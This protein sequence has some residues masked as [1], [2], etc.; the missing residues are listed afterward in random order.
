MLKQKDKTWMEMTGYVRERQLQRQKTKQKQ[1]TIK[2]K[3]S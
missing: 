1:T 3:K 2:K